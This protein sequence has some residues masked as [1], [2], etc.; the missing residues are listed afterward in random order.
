[1]R[2]S[3]PRAAALAL[4]LAAAPLAGA[5]AAGAPAAPAKVKTLCQTCHGLDGVALVPGAAN[6]SGQQREYLR[7]QL[8][9]FRSGKRQ[10]PQMGVVAKTLSDE[11][12]DAVADWYSSIRVTVA[13]PE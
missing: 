7:S 8:L 5:V 13:K 6:L 12:I 1:M 9:A 2:R 11:E 3:N 10:D 4:L